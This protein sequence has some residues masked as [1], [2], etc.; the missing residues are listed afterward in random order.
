MRLLNY[1]IHACL[2]PMFLIFYSYVHSG[3]EGSVPSCGKER[4]LRFDLIVSMA[5][6]K[7]NSTIVNLGQQNGSVLWVMLFLLML[8]AVVWMDLLTTDFFLSPLGH[9][10]HDSK[11]KNKSLPWVGI[12]QPPLERA[13]LHVRVVVR[14]HPLQDA[15]VRSVI[16][17]M[18]AQ[19]AAGHSSTNGLR[20]T[21]DIALVATEEL[22]VPVVQNIARGKENIYTSTYGASYNLSACLCVG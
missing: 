8:H 18:R 12:R 22:A 15:A 14:V 1:T 6:S 16:W 21:V 10:C 5:D 7:R 13:D 3:G 20:F 4:V 19:A 17:A 9:L 2:P 11:A